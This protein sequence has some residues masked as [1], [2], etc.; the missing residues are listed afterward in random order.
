VSGG[1]WLGGGLLST[2]SIGPLVPLMTA[3]VQPRVWPDLLDRLLW[4][5]FGGLLVFAFVAQLLGSSLQG[6]LLKTGG[7]GALFGGLRMATGRGLVLTCAA[8][9]IAVWS[10]L[11]GAIAVPQAQRIADGQPH[12]IQ[13]HTAPPITALADLRLLSFYNGA[14]TGWGSGIFHGFLETG[15]RLYNWHSNAMRFEERQEIHPWFFPHRPYRGLC[16]QRV[17]FALTLPIW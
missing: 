12:C 13:R 17:N 16:A 14:A 11:G 15:D 8:L 3:F 10:L 6:L 9:L 7:L 5:A 4:I 2:W 1:V